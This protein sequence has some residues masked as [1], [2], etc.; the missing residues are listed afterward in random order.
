METDARYM[1]LLARLVLVLI[2]A[3]VV[4]ALLSWMLAAMMTDGI[5]PLLSGEGIR[6]CFTHFADTF[7]SP[8]F[9]WMLLLAMAWGV[10]RYGGLLLL[11][12]RERR[13]LGLQVA[14][15]VLLAYA[16][17][18]MLLTLLPH[19]LLLSA[20]G[21]LHDSPFSRALLPIIAFGLTLCGVS[22]GIAVRSISSFTDVCRLLI[23]GLRDAAPLVLLFFFGAQFY[24]SLC[25]VF[26]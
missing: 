26:W 21:S 3:E 17:L 12:P 1:K 18:L 13:R 10:L 23:C 5:R 24:Y 25:Y 20:L 6:W 9:S 8:L 22:Y 2:L 14:I 11:R 4:L 19:A 16:L 7:S 15:M